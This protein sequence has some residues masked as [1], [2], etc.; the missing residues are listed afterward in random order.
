MPDSPFNSAKAVVAADVRRRIPKTVGPYCPPRHLGGHGMNG[1][2]I[3]RGSARVRASVRHG[4]CF[5]CRR[6]DLRGR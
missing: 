2:P 6:A 3:M 5:R 1:L 4:N